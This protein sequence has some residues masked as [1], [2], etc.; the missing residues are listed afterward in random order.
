LGLVEA[1]TR[2]ELEKRVDRKMWAPRY[3]RYRH[4]AD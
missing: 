4:K 1:T 2:E 3:L